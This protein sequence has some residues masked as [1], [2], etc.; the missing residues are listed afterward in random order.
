[1]EGDWKLARSN[2]GAVWVGAIAT[3]IKIRESACRYEGISA[4]ANKGPTR[5]AQEA[6]I[7]GEYFV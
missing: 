1:M 7:Y 3:N 4:E 6:K 2:G 5:R